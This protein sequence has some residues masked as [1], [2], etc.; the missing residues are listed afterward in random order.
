MVGLWWQIR[1][2]LIAYATFIILVLDEGQIQER[3]Q[4]LDQDLRISGSQG[5]RIS[6]SQDEDDDEWMYR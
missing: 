3:I 4:D 6:G 2:V 1:Q 5:P